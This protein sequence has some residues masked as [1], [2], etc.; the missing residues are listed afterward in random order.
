MAKEKNI[1]ASEFLYEKDTGKLFR[2]CENVKQ[3]VGIKN[4]YGYLQFW[5]N[6]KLY[7]VHR[8]V[9]FLT[10][11]EFAKEIDHKDRD[12]LNNRIDNLRECTR[13]QNQ[14]NRVYKNASGFRGV[15]ANKNKWA[16]RISYNGKWLHIGTFATKE[17]AAAAYNAKAKEL[18]GEF[19]ML[20]KI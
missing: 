1:D 19:A 5:Y 7:L 20:N 14:S 16:A 17:A 9:W 3:E 15:H 2:I 11:G 12:R 10:Y 13:S 18:V 6:K 4:A 8:F